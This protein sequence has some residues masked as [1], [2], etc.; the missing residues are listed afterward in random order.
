MPE[1]DYS[2][3][4]FNYYPTDAIVFT[5][6]I[7]GKWTDIEVTDNFHFNLHCF[8]GIFHY[9]P[10]CFEGMKAFE[11]VDGK[12][13]LFRPDENAK[14]MI[15]SAEYLDMPAPSVELFIE[16]CVRC[17]QAN[18][19]HIP[20]YKSG[21]SLYLRPVLFGINPQ[22]GIKSSNDVMFAVMASG[23]GTYSGARI[24]VPGDAVISRNYDRAATFG[25]GGYKLGANYAQSLHAYNLAHKAGY[26]E[27]LFLDSATHTH[28]EEFGSSNFFAIKDGTTYITP[29]SHSVL[30]SITNMSLRTVAEKEFGLKVERRKVFV[31]ELATFQEVNSCGT[32]VVITPIWRIDDK[33]TLESSENTHSY[34]ISDPDQCGPVSRRLYERIVGIQKG[35]Q[36]DTYNWNLFVDPK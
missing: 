5:K 17:V 16:A 18:W 14:R 26:R 6:C 2:K 29:N 19:R 23:V 8:A 11:G 27:L 22:L 7:D 36:E 32:A 21:A 12:V 13:R 28:I 25:S 4:S 30:P 31:D 1:I 15:R 10:S 24:L 20:P 3:R 33:L 35:L 34:I 9:A